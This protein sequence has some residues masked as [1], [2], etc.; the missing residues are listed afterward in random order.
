MY[1][2]PYESCPIS[3]P[4]TLT[5]MEKIYMYIQIDDIIHTQYNVCYAYKPRRQCRCC[6]RHHNH[7]GRPFVANGIDQNRVWYIQNSNKSM[8]F[9]K[10][11]DDQTKKKITA[12]RT[13]LHYKPATAIQKWNW[14][15]T[16]IFMWI[17]NIDVRRVFN[18]AYMYGAQRANG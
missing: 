9:K 1:I 2:F 5:D 4:L 6:F 12:H 18:H 11:T 10:L 8:G 16:S 17:L 14:Y 13:A 15:E 7:R 3:L